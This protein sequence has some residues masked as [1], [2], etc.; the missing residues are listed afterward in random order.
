MF[1][2]FLMTIETD[3][4]IELEDEV[5]DVVDDA[6]REELYDLDG[7]EEIVE[8]VALNMVVNNCNLSQ[9]DGWANQPDKNARITLNPD[10]TVSYIKEVTDA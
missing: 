5:I 2:K 8:H 3:I 7:A 6:W 1:R 10:W 9:L 4:E